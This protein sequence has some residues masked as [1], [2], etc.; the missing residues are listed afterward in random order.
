MYSRTELGNGTKVEFAF[1]WN[2][3]YSW[4]IRCYVDNKGVSNSPIILNAM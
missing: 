3:V 2:L 4:F 1:K